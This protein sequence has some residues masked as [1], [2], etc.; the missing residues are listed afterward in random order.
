MDLKRQ[1]GKGDVDNS[2]A[3]LHDVSMETGTKGN[4]A[5]LRCRPASPLYLRESEQEERDP[6]SAVG[7]AGRKEDG[8]RVGDDLKSLLLGKETPRTSSARI[9][10]LVR[11]EISVQAALHTFGKYTGTRVRVSR[12]TQVERESGLETGPVLAPGH[13][14]GGRK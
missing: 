14:S 10:H 8:Q 9:F 4:D 13:S 11:R 2:L 12:Y 3:E 6:G 1:R 7:D 5:G